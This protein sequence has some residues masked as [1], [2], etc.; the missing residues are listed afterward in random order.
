[1]LKSVFVKQPAEI[2]TLGV[3]FTAEMDSSETIDLSSSEVKAYNAAGNEVTDIIQ[4]GS[5][6]V[7]DSTKLIVTII[8]GANLENYK[9][10]FRASITSTKLLEHDIFVYIR[11]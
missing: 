10:S 2:V 11:D 8:N 4:S 1:M 3:D 7:L 9:I 5:F 6:D